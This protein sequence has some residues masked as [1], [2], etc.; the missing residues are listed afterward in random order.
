MKSVARIM[1]L[2]DSRGVASIEFALVFPVFLAMVFGIMEISRLM[3]WQVGLERA[4]AVASRCGGVAATDC[5]TDQQIAEKA[6]NNTPGLPF[7]TSQFIVTRENCGVR[8]SA[9]VTFEFV[10]GFLGLP[11]QPLHATFCHPLTQSTE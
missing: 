3:W 8:V 9:N 5:Q 4:T 6:A 7:L 2:I 11:D 1:K 10:T